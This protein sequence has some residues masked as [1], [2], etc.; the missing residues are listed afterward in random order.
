MAA[1]LA[2]YA[3]WPSTSVTVADVSP[4]SSAGPPTFDSDQDRLRWCFDAAIVRSTAPMTRDRSPRI[5][6][7]PPADS[8]QVHT[9]EWLA[10]LRAVNR[11]RLHHRLR[12]VL[13]DLL[14]DALEEIG[15]LD[16]LQAR[17]GPVPSR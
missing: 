2:E 10:A 9:A 1:A 5:G 4:N 6:D 3:Q 14:I 16:E 11:D 17:V 12:S 7:A 15:A 8:G 13:D